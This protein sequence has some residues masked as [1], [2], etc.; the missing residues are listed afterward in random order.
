MEQLT[1]SI[2]GVKK[3]TGLGITKIYELINEGKLD[4]VKV[5]KR[6]LVKVKSIYRLLEIS[7][8]K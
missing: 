3:A 1:T 5:G 8:A 4:T 6:T 7:D 2:D